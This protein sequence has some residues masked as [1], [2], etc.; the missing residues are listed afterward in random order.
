ML[1]IVRG[2]GGTVTSAELIASGARWE[3]LYRLRDLG[4]LVEISRGVYRIANA[5]A[6]AHL[7]LV[8]VC[9]RGS[10]DATAAPVTTHEHWF[11]PRVPETINTTYSY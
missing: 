5:P 2:A 7:D 1:E 3:D 9:R 11:L 10:S 6:T 8:A 4:V